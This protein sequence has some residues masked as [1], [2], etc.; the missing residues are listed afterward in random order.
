MVIKIRKREYD[1]NENDRILFNGACYQLITRQI[2]LGFD[3][4]IPIIPKILMEKLI[5]ESKVILCKEK[6]KS[7]LI[8]D[9]DLYKIVDNK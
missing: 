4:N 3:K 6:F 2:K 1:L 7:P 5:K 9:L 8:G